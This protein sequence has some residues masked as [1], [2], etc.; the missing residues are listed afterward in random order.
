MMMVRE[1]CRE[2]LHFRGPAAGSAGLLVAV[3]A[4]Y[5]AQAAAIAWAMA[6]VVRGDPA[7]CMAALAVVAV[8][9]AVR[10]GITRAQRSMAIRL[11]AMVRTA[12]RRRAMRAIL[13][14]S[15]LHDP[16]VRDGSVRAVLTDGID[17]I[18][19]YVSKYLPA[20][21]QVLI[22][23]PVIVVALAMISL[24]AAAIVGFG[25]LLAVVGPLMWKRVSARRG[26]DHWDSYESLSADL[27]ESLRSM[28][29]LRVLGDVAA[30][31][32]RID[33][34][35][36]ALRQATERTMRVSLAET[37]ITDFAVQAGLVAAAVVAIVNAVDGG[38]PA[39]STY[40]ILMLSA[41]AFRPVRDLSRH[42]HSGFLGVSAVPGLI[43]AGVFRPRDHGPHSAVVTPLTADAE[44]QRPDQ[45][46]VHD[47]AFT[48]PGSS[49]SVLSDITLVARRGTLCAV[50]GESGAGKSTLLD[51]ILGFLS[52][53]AGSIRLDGRPVQAGDIAV[54]S[55]RPVLFAGTIAE[56]LAVTGPARAEEIV[57]ACRSAG[58]LD[59]IT[60]FP[61]GFATE[62]TEAGTSLSGGQRQ[63]IAL[64][65]ALL[66]NRP[67]LLVDEPTSALDPVRAAEVIATLH[68]VAA[69]RIV[70]M[71]SH[72]PESLTEVR[73]VFR[74]EVA[75]Q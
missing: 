5:V 22:T 65:R 42:W 8:T 71:V 9:V 37:G 2:A 4:T 51:L 55:Q 64:A 12:L 48:Y 57:E 27:L 46:E 61:E 14:P 53:D 74:L 16:A 15:T 68:R 66:A 25:V 34:R 21:A 30:T 47:L 23:C 38:A 7:A 72:R 50:V 41:E 3:S 44:Y 28:A 59:D 60:G 58:V 35:S 20:A 49:H 62:V 17:G 33:A 24:P 63:R 31:R 1:L 6:A 69:D 73:D 67:V 52:P 26:L 10:L 54:V 39:T 56:N 32:H 18:D 11:G 19:A 75:P 36:E 40:L 70:I 29:T 13:R 45:L 43:S